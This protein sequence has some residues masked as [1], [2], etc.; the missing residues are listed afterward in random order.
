MCT[1]IAN[2]MTFD[3]KPVVEFTRHT[4]YCQYILL[5]CSFSI[6]PYDGPYWLNVNITAS[7]GSPLNIKDDTQK[8]MN[9]T[10]K[11]KYPYNTSFSNNLLFLGL[12]SLQ[13]STG[14]IVDYR[15]LQR[16]DLNYYFSFSFGQASLVSFEQIS[17]FN[18]SSVQLNPQIERLPIDLEP[19]KTQIGFKFRSH[20]HK[21]ERYKNYTCKCTVL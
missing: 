3:M 13:F 8:Y 18:T 12:E 11:F 6:Y 14:N 21:F 7:P 5:H 4:P 19:N 15:N 10:N 16:Y 2:V 17:V 9:I 20:N 1:G